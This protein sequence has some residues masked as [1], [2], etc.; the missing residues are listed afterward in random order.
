M[1]FGFTPLPP[2]HSSTGD[3]VFSVPFLI[4]YISTFCHL[5][6]GDIISTGSPSGSGAGF[7]PPRWLKPGEIVEIE[8]SEIG[9]LRNT[10]VVEQRGSPILTVMRSE[11][12][13]Q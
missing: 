5:M 3:M 8:I 10:V 6:P 13:T 7:D 4:S 12:D 9:V 1:F 2:S 11:L